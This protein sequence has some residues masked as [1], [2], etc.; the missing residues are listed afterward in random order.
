M[1]VVDA[2]V[3]VAHFE[4]TDAHHDRADT[5]LLE[6]AGEALAASPL[7]L[8]EVL[9]TPTRAGQV[10]RANAALTELGVVT[11]DLDHD[12]PARLATLR[13]TT[14]LRLP[15]CC[16][17]LAVEQTGAFLATFDERLAAAA[18]SHGHTVLGQPA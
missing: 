18:R 13:A 10:D 2:N 12:A 14:S 11:V 17:L 16:V 7:T 15:D 3:L 1:I 8:A 4:T 5:L 6:T 9:V